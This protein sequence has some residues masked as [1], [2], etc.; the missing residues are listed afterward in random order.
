MFAHHFHGLENRAQYPRPNIKSDPES[1]LRSFSELYAFSNVKERQI[2]WTK[3]GE[4]A[5]GLKVNKVVTKQFYLIE[6]EKASQE[7]NKVL[8]QSYIKLYWVKK[9][10]GTKSTH[11]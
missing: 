5:D 10:R 7:P 9:I 8:F 1:A 3:T 6:Q 4:G 11:H 2:S